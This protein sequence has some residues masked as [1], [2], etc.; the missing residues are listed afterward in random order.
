MPESIRLSRQRVGSELE[1]LK[2]VAKAVGIDINFRKNPLARYTRVLEPEFLIPNVVDKIKAELLAEIEKEM[3][4]DP[5]TAIL[6]QGKNGSQIY[7]KRRGRKKIVPRLDDGSRK[8]SP[9]RVYTAVD[10]N[11]E[12]RLIVKLNHPLYVVMHSGTRPHSIIP[13]GGVHVFPT[14]EAI[15]AGKA[16]GA[17]PHDELTPYGLQRLRNIPWSGK[18]DDGKR[19]RYKIAYP[20]PIPAFPISG[21]SFGRTGDTGYSEPKPFVQIAWRRVTRRLRDRYKRILTQQ[22]RSGGP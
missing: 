11:K 6:V 22:M 12:I 9:V 14:M 18:G 4:S 13:T 15:R 20:A 8:N 7:E 17:L 21:P 10:T 16:S 5:R 1:R 3:L 19:V 2:V